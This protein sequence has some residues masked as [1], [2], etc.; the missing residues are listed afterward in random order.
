MSPHA[1]KSEANDSATVPTDPQQILSSLPLRLRILLKEHY[2]EKGTEQPPI[3]ASQ[4]DA[5]PVTAAMGELLVSL[6]HLGQDATAKRFSTGFN[7]H[8]FLVAQ[9]TSIIKHRHNGRIP[10]EYAVWCGGDKF[11]VKPALQAVVDTTITL[12]SNISLRKDLIS[13][14]EVSTDRVAQP[15]CEYAPR[16]VFP[17]HR[18]T[19]RCRCG[20]NTYGGY[21]VAR[22][23]NTRR[24][25]LA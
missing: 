13:S 22:N 10:R 17:L 12:K 11:D 7:G 6:D 8:I 1:G 23:F 2:A 9:G 3:C 18:L 24:Q 15:S 5:E 20:F 14:Q 25:K 21:S 16:T 19:V 4:E